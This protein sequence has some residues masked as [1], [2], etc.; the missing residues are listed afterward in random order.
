[1]NNTY[2]A[3]VGNI[4]T[5]EPSSYLTLNS[6]KNTDL[7]V[8]WCLV[9]AFNY[10]KADNSPLC[11]GTKVGSNRNDCIFHEQPSTK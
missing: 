2:R 6:H 7:I 1:M 3:P 5:N 11:L 9:F 4:M 8:G 10:V